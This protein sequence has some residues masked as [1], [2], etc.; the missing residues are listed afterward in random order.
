MI[1]GTT[2]KIVIIKVQVTRYLIDRVTVCKGDSCFPQVFRDL[3]TACLVLSPSFEN[4]VNIFQGELTFASLCRN[5]GEP[6]LIYRIVADVT[7]LC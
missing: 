6:P 3:A 1:A 5:M 7:P 2:L 4:L